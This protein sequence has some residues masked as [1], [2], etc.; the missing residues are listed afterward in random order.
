[1]IKEE[2]EKE[3]GRVC[4]W[5]LQNYKAKHFDYTM[6]G[7]VEDPKKGIHWPYTIRKLS[8][9]FA[10]MPAHVINA[11]LDVNKHMVDNSYKYLDNT[12]PKFCV[13]LMKG[14]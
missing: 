11:V 2:A 6:Y 9:L 4:N 7:I 13:G 1:M 12:S 14:F 10:I 8:S 3:F 5:L